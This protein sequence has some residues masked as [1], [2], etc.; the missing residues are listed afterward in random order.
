MLAGEHSATV[1]ELQACVGHAA[2]AAMAIHQH[3]SVDRDRLLAERLVGP[4]VE[5]KAWAG[6]RNAS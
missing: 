5:S 6:Q 2:Q 3:G 1:A 4:E